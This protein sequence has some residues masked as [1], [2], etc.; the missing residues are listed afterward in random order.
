VRRL[1]TKYQDRVDFH[2]FDIDQ[3]P[4]HDLAVRYGVAGIPTIVLL[5]AN[6]GVFRLMLGEQS[7]DQLAAAIEDLLATADR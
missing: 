6:G 4:T 1:E 5:D 7:E 3:P 2:I